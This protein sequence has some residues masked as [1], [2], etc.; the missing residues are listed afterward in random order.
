MVHACARADFSKPAVLVLDV[1]SS[2][3]VREDLSRTIDL[4]A[5]IF[6]Q[7]GP[8]VVEAELGP[9]ISYSARLYDHDDPKLAVVQV[10]AELDAEFLI[11]IL[12]GIGRHFSERMRPPEPAPEDPS[13]R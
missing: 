9:T 3:E 10:S 6:S 1:L 4:P 2:R 5:P 11:G 7:L 12:E 8:I 13:R